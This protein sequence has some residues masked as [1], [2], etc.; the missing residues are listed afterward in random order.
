MN[1]AQRER[2]W[3][4]I[5]FGNP[6]DLPPCSCDFEIWVCAQSVNFAGYSRYRNEGGFVSLRIKLGW[7]HERTRPLRISALFAFK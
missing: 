2:T 1:A 6:K 5:L 7:N 3:A 4:E